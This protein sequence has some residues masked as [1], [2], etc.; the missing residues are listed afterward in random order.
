[1]AEQLR[2]HYPATAM[3]LAT[4]L[5]SIPPTTSFKSGIVQY[6]VKAFQREDVLIAVAAGVSWHS[7]AVEQSLN[8]AASRASI[9]AWLDSD[10]K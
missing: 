3:V 5:D 2:A 8:P 6:L 1:M 4:G 10:A 7:T 9:D